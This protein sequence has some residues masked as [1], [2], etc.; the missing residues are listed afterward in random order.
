MEEKKKSFK[1][2]WNERKF[3]RFMKEHPDSI[4]GIVGAL[5]TLLGVVLRIQHDKNEYD[6]YVFTTDQNGNTMK[7][8]AKEMKSV[9]G[10]YTTEED[11][12]N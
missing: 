10:N 3:V 1:E 12:P 6:S 11:I 2:W 5:I 7:I 9:K 8:P 4:F